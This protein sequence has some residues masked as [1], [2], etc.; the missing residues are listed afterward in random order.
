[1]KSIAKNR[2]IQI[3]MI[4]GSLLAAITMWL[5]VM[6]MIDPDTQRTIYNIPVYEIGT[7]DEDSSL[8]IRDGRVATVNITVRGSIA[9]LNRLESRRADIIVNVDMSHITTSGDHIANILVSLPYGFDNVTLI[10]FSPSRAA[11]S[12]VALRTRTVPVVVNTSDVL[13][14]EDYFV[15]SAVAEPFSLTL[16]GPA[17]V[18]DTIYEAV[19]TIARD[20]Y[21]T[22]SFT[23]LET[24]I[25]MDENGEQV[26]DADIIIDG[27]IHEIF[28]S[29]PV[30]ATR[31]V[32]LRPSFIAGGGIRLIDITAEVSQPTIRLRGDRELLASI[33]YISLDPPFELASLEG[34][35][36]T[37]T[38]TIL[39]PNDVV[40]LFD[41]N[42]VEITVSA[43]NIS[44]RTITAQVNVVNV[45][46]GY[47]V[48]AQESAPIELRGPSAQ[49]QSIAPG[50]VTIVVDL[51]RQE[52]TVGMNY[53]QATVAV[54]GAPAVAARNENF[55]IPINISTE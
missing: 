18:I 17:D 1:M 16:R 45:P 41:M 9:D 35:E 40:N 39:L 37:Y 51:E 20:E 30:Y 5:F 22:E 2:L 46:N 38:R 28:V 21:T 55:H 7:I 23:S 11:L 19:I 49:I 54:R 31:D 26:V 25:L 48:A 4:F 24:F 12:V 42:E 27:Y 3:A 29:V 44:T 36:Y 15:G 52:F 47:A 8:L 10:N 34:N 6:T 14:P 32:E 50:D 53:A 43:P 33:Q 13:V